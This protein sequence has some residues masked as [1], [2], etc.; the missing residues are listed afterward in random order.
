MA[1]AFMA[2]YRQALQFVI[3]APA[4]E[5][6]AREYEAGFFPHIDQAVLTATVWAYQQLGCW[7]LDPTI[8]QQSYDNL[9]EVFRFNGLISE[10]IPY[11]R[12]VVAPPA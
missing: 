6:A 12:F 10:A 11:S 9:L 3:T 2:A 7:C 5:I 8:S 4:E 1:G